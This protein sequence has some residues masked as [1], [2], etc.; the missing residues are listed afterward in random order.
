MGF[1]KVIGLI[2]FMF[3][4]SFALDNITLVNLILHKNTK[5]MADTSFDIWGKIIYKGIYGEIYA[6]FCY[7]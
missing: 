7:K 3:I 4:F 1:L 2:Y 5:F 6:E